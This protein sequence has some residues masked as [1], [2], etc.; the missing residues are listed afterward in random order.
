MGGGEVREGERIAE[1]VLS[2]LARRDL[3]RNFLRQERYRST[4]RL[5]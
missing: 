4:H 3:S 5:L 2:F 1:H